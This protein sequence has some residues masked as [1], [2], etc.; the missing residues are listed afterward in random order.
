M[1]MM[2]ASNIWQSHGHH[3]APT[4]LN[5]NRCLQGAAGK[6]AGRQIQIK[7]PTLITR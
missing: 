4:V 3:F 1:L 2:R 6:A 5:V 7:V